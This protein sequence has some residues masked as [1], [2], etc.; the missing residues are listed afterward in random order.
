MWVKEGCTVVPFPAS[1]LLKE[2]AHQLFNYVR[3]VF[4]CAYENSVYLS[5]EPFVVPTKIDK[6]KRFVAMPPLS[7]IVCKEEGHR[8]FSFVSYS[9]SDGV[10]AKVA[11]VKPYI[12]SERCGTITNLDLRLAM[13][14]NEGVP[15]LCTD[16]P[17][18]D[19]SEGLKIVNGGFIEVVEGKEENGD[20]IEFG[21]LR[22]PLH[23]FVLKL[24]DII[25]SRNASRGQR[26]RY[27]SIAVDRNLKPYTN[28]LV[29]VN[30]FPAALKI[31]KGYVFALDLGTDV[32][33]TLYYMLVLMSFIKALD[34]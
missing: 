32:A 27:R 9:V 8:D 16:K 14:S 7:A 15:Y 5:L 28:I 11:L 13:N 31:G 20:S 21:V 25:G 3:E 33:K 24:V 2:G 19:F 22:D 30:G 4:D 34:R 6:V 10:W 23:V 17:F 1:A 26:V 12:T 18:V 29:S